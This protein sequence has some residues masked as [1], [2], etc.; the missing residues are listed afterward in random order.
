[1]QT[2]SKVTYR[3]LLYRVFLL[4]YTNSVMLSQFM[5]INVIW[6]YGHDICIFSTAAHWC[7]ELA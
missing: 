3:Q 5:I 2:D 1:M 6:L 7:E 4:N